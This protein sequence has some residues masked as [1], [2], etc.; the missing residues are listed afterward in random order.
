MENFSKRTQKIKMPTNDRI[1][2]FECSINRSISRFPFHTL[3]V[4]FVKNILWQLLELRFYLD[5]EK[6][7]LPIPREARIADFVLSYISYNWC[8]LPAPTVYTSSISAL[9]HRRDPRVVDLVSRCRA[10]ECGIRFK[11][12]AAAC[13]AYV[14]PSVLPGI[15]RYAGTSWNPKPGSFEYD[16]FRLRRDFR[17]IRYI[18]TCESMSCHESANVYKLLWCSLTG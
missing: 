14:T 7:S 9:S 11:N 2:N 16:G 18:A 10:R 6:S 8:F 1:F 3:V 12:R 4:F 15:S 13:L 5:F 17:A